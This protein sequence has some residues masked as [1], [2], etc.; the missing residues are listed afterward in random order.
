[1]FAK[2]C[3]SCGYAFTM[4]RYFGLRSYRFPCPGCGTPLATSMR[5]AVVAVFVQAPLL[6]LMISRAMENPWYWF[7][8][9]PVFGALFLIHYGCFAV[10]ADKPRRS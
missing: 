7:A 3:P 1:M 6:A 2:S 8:L 10:V 4:R 5:H 9:P